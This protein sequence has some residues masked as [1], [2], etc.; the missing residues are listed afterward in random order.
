MLSQLPG[1]E[2]IEKSFTTSS[3]N[4]AIVRSGSA[5]QAVRACVFVQAYISIVVLMFQHVWWG[6]SLEDV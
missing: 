4:A 3:N 1:P 5:S 6:K 2:L